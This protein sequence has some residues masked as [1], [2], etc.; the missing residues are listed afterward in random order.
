MLDCSESM[1]GDKLNKMDQGLQAIVRALRTDPQALETVYISVIAFAGIAQTIAPLVE[2]ASFYPPRLP[3]GGGTSL[4][5]A[6]TVLMDE[7]DQRVVKTTLD[8]KGDWKPIVYLF[9]DGHPTDS[10]NSTIERWNAGYANKATLIAIGLGASADFSALRRL[11]EHVIQFEDSN[12]GDFKKFVDW[13]S[14]SVVVQSKHVNEANNSPLLLLDPSIMQLLKQ[15]P[16]KVADETCVT[17]VGRCT[18]SKKP[19]IMKY[20]QVKQE[21]QTKNFNFDMKHYELCGCYALDESYFE[22][23]D[24]REISLQVSTADL[25]GTPGCPHCGNMSA[26]AACSCG[27]LMCINGPQEA[28]CPWCAKQVAFSMGQAGEDNH[29]DVHRGRG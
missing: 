29:F 17:L 19:Y 27:K 23:S 14:A 9:T 16:S 20:E 4:G 8:R 7:I 12:P 28:T 15:P 6:M 26:F 21:L 24:Q 1:A 11:T 18:K 13:V 25:L 3:L 10:L 22:W 2:L 5:A